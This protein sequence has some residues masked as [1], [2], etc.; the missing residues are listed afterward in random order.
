MRA[1]RVILLFAIATIALPG[2]ARAQEDCSHAV[3]FT[4]PGVT[5]DNLDHDR[6]T[7]VSRAIEDGAIG[8]MSVRTNTARTSYASGFATIGAG[9][10]LDGGATTG[11]PVASE[12]EP[13]AELVRRDVTV[14]GLSEM[15]ELAESAGYEAVPGALGRAAGDIPTIAIGNAESYE[16]SAPI[17]RYQRWPLLAAMDARGVVDVSVT[18]TALVS[19]SDGMAQTDPVIASVTSAVLEEEDCSIAV[20]DHGDL[21]RA[22]QHLAPGSIGDARRSALAAA[23]RLLGDVRATLDPERDLLVI[24]SPTSPFEADQAHFGVAIAVGPGFEAGELLTSATTGRPGIVTLPDIAPTL[25]VHHGVERPASM[26][27]RPMFGVEARGDRVEAALELDRESTFVDGIRAAIWT[28]YVILELAVYG[29]IAYYL[30]RRSQTRSPTANHNVLQ[31]AALSLLAFP[32]ATFLIGMTTG[33]E[34]GVVGYIA[35][36]VGIV[37]LMVSLIWWRIRDPLDRV[38]AIA[39]ITTAVMLGDLLLGSH[40]QLNTVFSYS[41]IVAGRF[42]GIGNIGFAV[43]GAA[44]I[45]TAALAVRKVASYPLALGIVAALFVVTVVVDG[46]PAFGSDV[47]G[48]LALV[49]SL[50]LTWLLLRGR[51]PGWKSVALAIAGTLVAVGTFLVWDLSLPEESRTHLGRLFEDVST[52]GPEVFR[53]TIERKIRANLRVFT[54]TIWTYLVPPLL[55]FVGWLMLRPA[56][57]W[58]EIADRFPSFRSGIVGGLILAALGFAVNDSGI[59]VPAVILSM[60]VP[61][62]LTVHLMLERER[63]S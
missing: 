31:G 55:L 33:H 36:L 42:T 24:V 32:V 40:L 7:N 5:W 12:P 60:L 39:T 61:A 46:A 10:R 29:A 6:F 63:S 27:G 45:L 41:P 2:V 62:V 20:I 43:L 26:L 19:E 58:S 53:E 13:D 59:V 57:R 16:P 30:W 50:G 35:A 15:Q 44:V 38:L 4:L 22:E 56:G 37:A 3:V 18:G 1:R 52:R 8:S 54:S 21:I 48:T 17:V 34:L 49:P 25:L 47:G 14:A 9:T 51:K 11:G 28:A 23:D